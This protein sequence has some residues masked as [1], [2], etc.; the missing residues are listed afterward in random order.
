[1][2]LQQPGTIGPMRLKNRVIMVPMGTNYGTSAGFSTDRDKR[3]YGERARV[4]SP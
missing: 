1:M 2:L 4:V 3:Y